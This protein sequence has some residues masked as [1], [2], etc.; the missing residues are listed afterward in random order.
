[1]ALADGRRLM[2]ER[3]CGSCTACCTAVP[4][5]EIGV[6]AFTR[7]PH[8]RTPPDAAIGCGIYETRPRSCAKWNCQWYAEPEW[9]DELRP[10]RLGVIVDIMPDLVSINGQE[11]P[12]MQLWVL[13]GHEDAYRTDHRAFDLICSIFEAGHA[14]IWRTRDPATP[15][16]QLGRVLWRD[17]NN[18]RLNQSE[19]NWPDATG[20]LGSQRQRFR[21]ALDLIEKP[22][23]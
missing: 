23:A 5:P 15:G 19:L 18:G 13:P 21:R 6:R 12:A 17:P 10:D 11:M 16:D 2:V 9:P 8:V 22:N 3:R 4:V 7:C 1:M 14:V 20:K